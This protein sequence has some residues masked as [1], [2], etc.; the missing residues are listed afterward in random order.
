MGECRETVRLRARYGSWE[1]HMD[2]EAAV[3]KASYPQYPFECMDRVY[4]LQSLRERDGRTSVMLH[5]GNGRAHPVTPA[6]F[7]VRTRVN[8]YGGKC[9]CIIGNRIIFNNHAD[10]TLY[11]QELRT[12][13]SPAV[14][15]RETSGESIGFA[16][17]V[18]SG[19]G[20]WVLAVSERQQDSES[21]CGIVAIPYDSADPDRDRSRDL[22]R[23]ASGSDFYAAPALS[24]DGSV[25]AWMEWSV[26][27]MPWDRTRLM[28]SSVCHEHGCISLQS[29]TAAVD[30]P[31]TAVCQPGFLPD[32]TLVFASDSPACNFWNLFAYR[33]QELVQITDEQAEFG[34]A[35]WT[36]GQNRWVASS[37]SRVIAICTRRYGDRIVEVN[38][39]TGQCSNLSDE[40]ASCSHLWANQRG[41]VLFVAHHDDRLAE[42]VQL[43]PSKNRPA[44]NVLTP[45]PGMETCSKPEFLE[46]P[47]GNREVAYG[48]LY[49]PCNPGYA[50]LEGTLPPL[51][52]MV[53]GG[54]TSRAT[55]E[56]AGIKQYFCS[57]GFAV[58]DV[59]HRGSTGFGR[60]YRQS[61]LGNWGEH[62]CE[63]IRAGVRH[64]LQ[65]GLADPR[66]VF[67]RGGSAGG[68]AVL[69]ALTRHAALFCAG[70]SYYGIGNL[71]TLSEIT[72]RFESRYTDQL[73]GE[74]FDPEVSRQPDSLFVRRSPVFDLDRIECPLILFQ[75]GQDRVVP[76]SLA[77]EVVSLLEQKGIRHAY[78]EYPE[79][80]HGFRQT[81]NRV[82]SLCR[83]THFFSS[84]VC[85]SSAEVST[86]QPRR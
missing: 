11:C 86:N 15:A 66:H 77:R 67:I 43:C 82:D 31:D 78:H 22:I 8:E 41:E 4:W 16:D 50:G 35:H 75:G 10:G 2:I 5:V 71:I 37:D 18:V 57:L 3:D 12:G 6:E 59:N 83:E 40:F 55:R 80:G 21:S 20:S 81:V 39:K 65:E 24:P 23:L 25:L 47:T 27:D 17:L 76:P 1:S 58:L 79:E 42:V 46:F 84:L 36:F 64:V 52:V 9:F 72:H 38:V 30:N 85:A 53:H 48:Y 29:V 49:R 33:G 74:R 28:V 62:D 54:P 26:P 73:I 69:R 13:S 34:E 14:F 32:G 7:D 56:Y 61:L 19:C 70:A 60:T 51:V 44:S 63:D 45:N 68:Y